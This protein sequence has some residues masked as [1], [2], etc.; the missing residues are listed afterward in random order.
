M[1]QSMGRIPTTREE[2]LLKFWSSWFGDAAGRE[3][4][5]SAPTKTGWSRVYLEDPDAFLKHVALCEEQVWPCYLS[6][7]NYSSRGCLSHLDRL[8]WDFDSKEVPPNLA[9]AWSE[10]RIIQRS[11]LQFYNLESLIVESGM[12]GYHVYVFLSEPVRFSPG[13]ERLA[14][15][16]IQL[17]QTK[18]LMG[19][20]LR[21]LDTSTVGDISRLARVPYTMHE[22]KM[23]GDGSVLPGGLCQPLTPEGRPLIPNPE[24]PMLLRSRGVP[25]SMV[26]DA[27]RRAWMGEEIRRLRLQEGPQPQR[28]SSRGV[29]P[30]IESL[31]R[32][33]R[34]PHE[35]RVAIVAEYHFRAGLGE[36][37]LVDLFRGQPDFKEDRTRYQVRHILRGGYKPFRCDTIRTAGFCLGQECRRMAKR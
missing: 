3:S 25:P 33:S 1:T 29:R 32:R 7:N 28:S 17:L 20:K 35:M 31:L 9:V 12:K 6:V 36:D 18:F 15:A 4:L 2:D 8:F 23:L 26:G 5:E 22:P 16:A 14:K 13:E 11:L 27:V 10:A 37:G 21:I 30:C 19:L 34:I 24:L